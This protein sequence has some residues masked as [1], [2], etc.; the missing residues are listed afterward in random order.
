VGT[1]RNS[2]DYQHNA[3]SGCEGRQLRY[4][5]QRELMPPGFLQPVEPRALAAAEELFAAVAHR[6]TANELR[7]LGAPDDLVVR[8]LA[9][10]V[11]EHDHAH[12]QLAIAGA[13]ANWWGPPALPIVSLPVGR[14]RAIAQ[15]GGEAFL[16]GMVGEAAAARAMRR[17]AAASSDEELS[18]DLIVMAIDEERHAAL[19]SDI[20]RWALR[21]SRRTKST[22]RMI[23]RRLSI[24]PPMGA[25]ANLVG[26][27]LI[28]RLD[29]V[30]AW[31]SA[32]DDADLLV[33]TLR[34]SAT[35]E[36]DI[37]VDPFHLDLAG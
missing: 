16:D 27:P 15:L 34:I 33:S 17:A 14:S 8:C 18:R 28:S 24:T 12:R 30:M 1:R 37:P 20:V 4:G 11:D 22:I 10:S 23:R 3:L 9:A 21:E 7:S 31:G 2:K 25:R 35:W 29:R 6:L 26:A 5:R 13:D 36:D 32:L 19:A